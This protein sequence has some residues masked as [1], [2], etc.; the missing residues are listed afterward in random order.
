METSPT[1]K[2]KASLS[3][4]PLPTEG[5]DPAREISSLVFGS[6]PK[7]FAAGVEFFRRT[8]RVCSILQ[9]S[10]RASCSELELLEIDATICRE[11]RQGWLDAWAVSV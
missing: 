10:P 1:F 3:C 11:L 9:P 7:D 2:L 5:I 6:K 4:L 8:L